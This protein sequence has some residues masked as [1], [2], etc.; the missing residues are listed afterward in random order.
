MCTVLEPG[1]YAQKNDPQKK[2]RSQ[3]LI[4]VVIPYLY[5][6]VKMRG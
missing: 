4:R 6:L 3:N 1:S 5:T 2:L